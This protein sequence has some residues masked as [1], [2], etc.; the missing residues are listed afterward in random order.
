[1][2]RIEPLSNHLIVKALDADKKSAG[3]IIIPEKA[4]APK[5]E[6]TVKY[7]G[8]GRTTESGRVLPMRVKVGDVILYAKYA[9]TEIKV[10]DEDMICLIEDDVFGIIR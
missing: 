10:N 2:S 4:Q 9:G 7:V 1:M 6:A 3:G 5:A 8:P